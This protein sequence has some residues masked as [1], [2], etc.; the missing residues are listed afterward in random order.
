MQKQSSIADVVRNI[1]IMMHDEPTIQMAV[2]TL[3][4]HCLL[5]GLQ[6]RF[7]GA[8]PPTPS[9]SQ[10][11]H[12]YFL[13][14]CRDAIQSFLTVGFAAYRIRFNEKGAKIPEI[15]PLGTYTWQVARSN[16][17]LNATPWSEIG[18]APSESSQ[19][20][21]DKVDN[22]PLLRYV[23]HCSHCKVRTVQ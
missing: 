23:V 8:T 20:Q 3:Q 10:H 2:R 17:G 19:K 12:R 6:L 4:S 11:L 5:G 13:P 9:F 22:Q 18:K 15:L 21:D 1:G 14:F 16:Q 7:G